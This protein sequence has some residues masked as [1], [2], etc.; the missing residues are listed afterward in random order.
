MRLIGVTG[1]IAMGKSTVAD[2][3]SRLGGKVIDTDD[4]A[5]EILRPH[6]SALLELGRVFGPSLICADGGLKRSVLADLI[7][8]DEA[9]RAVVHGIVHPRVREVWQGVVRE[10][11]SSGVR[12]GVVIIPLLYETDAQAAFDSVAVV[13]CT[14]KTQLARIAARGWSFNELA[15][16]SRAQLPIAEKTGR[17]DYVLWNES[18]IEVLIDQISCVNHTEIAVWK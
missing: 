17:G 4:V 11:R 12:L 10:W 9:A 8:E 1:G 18:S 15:R 7:F 16:R 6:S 2:A 13:A 14:E 5:R 3:W